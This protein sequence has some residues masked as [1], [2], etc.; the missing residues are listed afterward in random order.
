MASAKKFQGCRIMIYPMD[1]EELLADT[2]ITAYNAQT[3]VAYIP[4]SDVA[5]LAS[6]SVRVRILANPDLYEY[7][8]T[9]RVGM[10]HIR[11][12]AVAL[13]RERLVKERGYHRHQVDAV[14]V[15]E[16]VIVGKQELMLH[17]PM[18]VD[19]EDI[20]GGGI[21]FEAGR[22]DFKIGTRMR[23]SVDL[24][25]KRLASIYE[26]VRTQKEMGATIQYGCKNLL[27]SA[28]DEKSL[29]L[30][31]PFCT[32]KGGGDLSAYEEQ[33]KKLE[34][35][36]GYLELM[37]A[38]MEIKAVERKIMASIRA[39]DA[40][41]ILNI[42]H[43]RRA[44]GEKDVRHTLNRALLNGL[45]GRW[46]G[47]DDNELRRLVHIGCTGD[48][49]EAAEQEK[50]ITLISEG[51]DTRAAFPMAE[52]KSAV[53]LLFLEQLHYEGLNAPD[54]SRLMLRRLLADHILQTLLGRRVMLRDGSIATVLYT[55]HND[56]GRPVIE[57]G[58]AVK[59]L[60][61]PWDIVGIMI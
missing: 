30:K 28:D 10:N 11:D 40:A 20:S 35:E 3:N 32:E 42:V 48:V 31:I 15:I 18:S 57:I 53:P 9:I 7:N 8:A 33:H 52:E 50:Q 55:L 37:A 60:E 61:H 21:L 41:V 1:S 29:I 16:S 44:E 45:M 49:S 5:D 39:M 56:I 59:Q 47:V 38:A 14:G 22:Y 36:S 25:G 19:I 6:A 26:I 27:M 43:R 4:K 23:L 34:E 51:Y 24:K 2:T 12:A 17:R 54:G 13:Y 46:L 58:R